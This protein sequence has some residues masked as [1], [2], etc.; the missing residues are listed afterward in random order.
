VS[1]AELLYVELAQPA[2]RAHVS[3]L[4]SMMRCASEKA[5]LEVL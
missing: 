4:A 5:D 1:A 2:T 3:M